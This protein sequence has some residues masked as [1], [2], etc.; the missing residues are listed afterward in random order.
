MSEPQKRSKLLSENPKIF[1]LAIL[2]VD[3]VGHQII[4]KMLAENYFL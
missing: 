4:T 2:V 1:A 3:F